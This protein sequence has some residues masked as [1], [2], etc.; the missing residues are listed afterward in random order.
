MTPASEIEHSNKFSLP[1][2]DRSLRITRRLYTVPA[3][4]G[5]ESIAPTD[6]QNH[7]QVQPQNSSQNILKECQ[8]E[9]AKQAP[10][11]S[12]QPS[13]PPTWAGQPATLAKGKPSV[14]PLAYTALARPTR[15]LCL[16]YQNPK[17]ATESECVADVERALHQRWFALILEGVGRECDRS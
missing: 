10:Q 5:L 15:T 12:G 16:R 7:K 6:P 4:K 2:Q 9:D 3:S 11:T 13:R 14:T 8:I 17:A 1:A